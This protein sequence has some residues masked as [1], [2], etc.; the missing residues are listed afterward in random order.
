MILSIHHLLLV[1][2]LDW[3]NT[4]DV[5]VITLSPDVK[6]RRAID[7]VGI[8]DCQDNHV[9]S[10]QIHP[11]AQ[12]DSETLVYEDLVRRMR[13]HRDNCF[14]EDLRGAVVDVEKNCEEQNAWGHCG[15]LASK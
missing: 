5:P 14:M 8:F 10:E 13:N 9:S 3:V 1:G 11:R 6:D 12:R 15:G 4:D 7:G 2:S